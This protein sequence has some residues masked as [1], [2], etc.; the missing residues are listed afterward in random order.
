MAALFSPSVEADFFANV[1][2]IQMRRQRALARL[3]Q[4]VE[5]GATGT[6]TLPATC[7]QCCATQ[8]AQLRREPRLTP[9]SA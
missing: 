8:A 5:A 3:K 7:C 4:R 2:H 1:T 6:A 9:P